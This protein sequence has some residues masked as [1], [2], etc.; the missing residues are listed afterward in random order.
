M[1]RAVLSHPATL[2]VLRTRVI[3]VKIDSDQAPDLIARLRVDSLPTDIFLDARGNEV[4]RTVGAQELSR[5][6]QMLGALTSA[7]ASE[8]TPRT[9]PSGDWR[10][11]QRTQAHGDT[12]AAKQ[13]VLSDDG[14]GFPL[15]MA[16]YSPVALAARRAWTEGRTEYSVVYKGV[17]YRF[18]DETE[19]QAFEDRPEE[20]VPCLHG[21]DPV[22]YQDSRQLALGLLS[23]CLRHRDRVYFFASEANRDTFQRDPARYRDIQCV[24]LFR[25]ETSMIAGTP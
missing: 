6:L 3:G 7:P 25:R 8:T 17:R 1:E 14:D 11:E 15:G 2:D 22:A 24:Q 12:R 16:G 13:R 21:F 19:A 9:R 10:G 5:Y 4:A 23:L 20:F 18:A